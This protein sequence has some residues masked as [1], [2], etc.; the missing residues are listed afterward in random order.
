M[1]VLLN[2]KKTPNS[3][4]RVQ[5][6]FQFQNVVTQSATK[7][8]PKKEFQDKKMLKQSST[9]CPI[10]IGKENTKPHKRMLLT[11]IPNFR[12]HLHHHYQHIVRVQF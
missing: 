11:K 6:Q 3:H 5:L 7:M 4:L 2:S 1:L 9:I 8:C 12:F 10:F